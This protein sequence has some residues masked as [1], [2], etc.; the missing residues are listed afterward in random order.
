MWAA[1]SQKPRAIITVLQ[2]GADAKARNNQGKTA[3]TYA[4]S[5]AKPRGTDAL[6]A[7]QTAGK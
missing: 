1:H 2:A 3:L 7:L 5:S 4:I 6:G